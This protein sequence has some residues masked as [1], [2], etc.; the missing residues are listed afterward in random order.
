M[1]FDVFFKVANDAGTAIHVHGVSLEE[2]AAYSAA[3]AKLAI[4]A[5]D[6]N[7]VHVTKI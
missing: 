4:P 3:L 1:N 2:I 5:V 7:S 6:V